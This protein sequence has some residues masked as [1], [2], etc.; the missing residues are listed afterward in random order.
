MAS[1]T[2]SSQTPVAPAKP[3]SQTYSDLPQVKAL[4]NPINLDRSAVDSVYASFTNADTGFISHA[5][6]LFFLVNEFG[7]FQREPKP[8]S[9]VRFTLFLKTNDATLQ[10]LPVPAIKE[11][12]RRMFSI[13]RSLD[14]VA[15]YDF[16]FAIL[17]PYTNRQQASEIVH[18]I[19]HAIG[20]APLLPG[21]DPRQVGC[22]F[23]IACMPDD[24]SHPGVLLAAA[25]EAKKHAQENQ[26]AVTTFA[27]Y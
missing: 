5:A 3:A 16:E 15:H 18:K 21:L 22:H 4:P 25:E 26:L 23:G 12:G 17:L 14:W 9:V 20:S 24:C 8:L 13:M 10:P 11:A 19:A 2:A 6:F 1:S 27:D 7:R